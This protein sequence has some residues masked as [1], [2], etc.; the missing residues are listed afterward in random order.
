MK[1]PC[2]LFLQP[3]IFVDEERGPTLGVNSIGHEKI[4]KSGFARSLKFVII[5][6][7]S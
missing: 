3:H 7:F 2:A 5:K 6:D 1:F 4:E